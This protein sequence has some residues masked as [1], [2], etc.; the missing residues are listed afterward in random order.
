MYLTSV[1]YILQILWNGISKEWKI[2]LFLEK[3]GP[4]F[5]F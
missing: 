1:N 3:N 4:I 2:E 5:D